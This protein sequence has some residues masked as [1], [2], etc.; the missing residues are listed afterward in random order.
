MTDNN[1]ISDPLT[2]ENI[3]SVVEAPIEDNDTAKSPS[4][5]GGSRVFVLLIGVVGVSLV[6]GVW[7]FMSPPQ[8]APS[9]VDRPPR[10]EATPGGVVQETSERFQESLRAQNRDGADRAISRGQSFIPDPEDIPERLDPIP[11][12]DIDRWSLP[13]L[14][15]NDPE[16]VVEA[17]Q[18][19]ARP[20][21]AAP[22]VAPPPPAQVSRPAPSQPPQQV[23]VNPF[24]ASIL[25][26]MQ[27]VSGAW[28]PPSS[29]LIDLRSDEEG[30]DTPSSNEAGSSDGQVDGAP[31]SGENGENG[32]T[33]VNAGA[34][35]Y[36]EAITTATSDLPGPVAA[37]IVS[38]EFRG[39]RLIGEFATADNVQRM[40][41]RFSLM[42]LPDGRS[43]PI[44]AFAVDGFSAETAV[45]S[46][47][48]RRLLS[49]Y[50]P[51]LAAS[52]VT[53]FANSA[54]QVASTVTEI[55]ESASTST[56]EPSRDNNIA[57]GLA[58][59]G[60]VISNDILRNRPVGPEI[61]VEA[62]FPMGILFTQPLVAESGLESEGQ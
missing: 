41:I 59:A 7:F 38:G 34:V 60:G 55:G 35:L 49:R 12:S 39:S 32:V 43:L 52:F 51:I 36:A 5:S 10:L 15:G 47:V 42:A 1:N 37:E 26:Q 18:R 24:E 40:V 14:G 17:P 3:S 44:E 4:R 29:E 6:G 2:G 21:I 20:S 48:N 9:S 56:S 58:Q 53:G 62:G 31:S 50:G 61:R 54:S 46:D 57:A 11:P 28:T 25:A 45:A 16:P 8:Q 22:V 13:R 30:G 23:P 27:A 33:L 19:P